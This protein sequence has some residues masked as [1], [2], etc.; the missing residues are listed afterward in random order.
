MKTCFPMKKVGSI[1]EGTQ[2]PLPKNMY[3]RTFHAPEQGEVR[4]KYQA[5]ITPSG[6][7]WCEL[8]KESAV[9]T[10]KASKPKPKKASKPSADL[11]EETTK[12][13]IKETKTME[14]SK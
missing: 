6:V 10:K 2:G 14:E 3:D 1:P 5:S 4:D 8:V 9:V 11:T 12:S 7:M 13:P